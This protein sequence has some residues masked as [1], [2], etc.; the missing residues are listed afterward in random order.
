MPCDRCW[1]RKEP[2]PTPA[3]R[4]ADAA[5]VEITADVAIEGLERARKS[6]ERFD[7]AGTRVCEAIDFIRHQQAEVEQWKR[8]WIEDDRDLNELIAENDKLRAE[9]AEL[10]ERC[11]ET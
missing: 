2:D 11:G 1:P 7:S 5:G 3:P 8:H 10:R 9:N 6:I 4:P